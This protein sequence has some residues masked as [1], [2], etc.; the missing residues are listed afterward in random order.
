MRVT[1]IGTDFPDYEQAC[2]HWRG[3]HAGLKRLP[4]VEYQFLSCRPGLN[5]EQVK[6]FK[7]DLIV[8]GLLDMI[9]NKEQRLIIR[10]E[11]P[12]AKIVFW[13]GDL[14]RRQEMQDCSEI[15]CMFVSNDGQEDFY[16][17]VFKMKRV[18][19]LPLGCEPIDKPIKD[20]RFEIPFLFIGAQNTGQDFSWRAKF[21]ED[22]K[23]HGLK[24]VNSV[25]ATWRKKIYEAMPAMYSSSRVVLDISHYINIPS[26][27]SIRYF[28]IPAFYGFALT[29]RFPGC[30]KLYDS[31]MRVYFDSMDEAIEKK[32]YYLRNERERWEMVEK[33]H[34]HSFN[35]TYDKRFRQMFSML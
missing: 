22:F 24:V 11:N 19:F 32:D 1:I 5:T 7:P 4:D 26:Y 14:R 15:D 34:A 17:G 25:E 33:A 30:E 6:E 18:E 31:S 27:T 23:A 21:I 10:E 29:R 20:K 16:K 8:Y 3:I 13:Y 35:H 12:Q 9:K 2:P 28:E